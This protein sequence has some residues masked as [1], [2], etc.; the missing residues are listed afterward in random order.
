MLLDTY[1]ANQAGP[2]GGRIFAMFGVLVAFVSLM[3]YVQAH[4]A[5]LALPNL[6]KCGKSHCDRFEPSDEKFGDQYYERRWKQMCQ[7]SA[8]Y[9]AMR[10]AYDLGKAQPCK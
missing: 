7:G 6:I 8:R 1:N 4:G 10:E 5:D 2:R 3:F 9:D